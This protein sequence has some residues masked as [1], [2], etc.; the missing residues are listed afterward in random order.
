[1]A[2][3]YK[4]APHGSVMMPDRSIRKAGAHVTPE[5]FPSGIQ[6]HVRS[7]YV[8]VEGSDD[9][10]AGSIPGGAPLPAV[11][12]D[13]PMKSTSGPIEV[14]ARK[15]V[16]VPVVMKTGLFKHDPATLKGKKLSELNAMILE[17]SPHTEPMETKEEAIA[18][19]SSDLT[20]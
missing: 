17:K 16:P 15:E 12:G 7:G 9:A 14:T 8:I 13:V 6:E 10:P 3:T 11:S 20:K 1:M 18:F 4:V 19:L 5:D 2:K